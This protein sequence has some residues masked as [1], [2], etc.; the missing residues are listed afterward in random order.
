MADI[1]PA[2]GLPEDFDFDAVVE[3]ADEM[4]AELHAEIDDLQRKIRFLEFTR[5]HF[6]NL[7]AQRLAARE[8]ALS[9]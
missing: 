8:A 9:G 1:A 4:H 7:K 6:L 5:E 3:T 2:S